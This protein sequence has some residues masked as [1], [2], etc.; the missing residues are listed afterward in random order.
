MNQDPVKQ[1][2]ALASALAALKRTSA[3]FK[4]S[5]FVQNLSKASKNIRTFTRDAQ[6]LR[7]AL[8]ENLIETKQLGDS[9]SR[10][11]SSQYLSR[12]KAF[13]KQQLSWY[14]TKALTFKIMALP[15]DVLTSYSKFNDSLTQIRSVG[16]LTDTQMQNLSVTMKKVGSSTKF[17]A[18]EIAEAA[19][20]LA[21]AGFRG[22]E[23]SAALSPAAKLSTATNA[24][25]NVATDVMST[26]I[27]AYN[28]SSND[29]INISDT[30]TNAVT[31]SKLSLVDLSTAFGYV[32]SAAS[33]TG[34]SFK[35]TVTLLSVLANAGLKASTAATGLRMALLKITAPTRKAKK[36]LA[37]LGLSKADLDIANRGIKQVLQT[38]SQLDTTDIIDIFGARSANAV[39]VFKNVSIDALNAVERLISQSGT[40]AA[41]A[42]EQMLSL[43]K[44]WK[45]LQDKLF[46]MNVAIGETFGESL[47]TNV[48]A[49]GNMV[50]DLTKH[51]SELWTVVKGLALSFG[52][53]KLIKGLGYGNL[54]KLAKG[55]A[56]LWTSLRAG[57]GVLVS[58]GASA[59]VAEGALFELGVAL[60]PLVAL[61]AAFKAYDYFSETYVS[62]E[63]FR[64][65]VVESQ[66]AMSRMVGDAQNLIITL[67]RLSNLQIDQGVKDLVIGAAREKFSEDATTRYDK[68]I[69]AAS[70]YNEEVAKDLEAQKKAVLERIKNATSSDE[71]VKII[72]DSRTNLENYLKAPT[73]NNSLW[74]IQI[75]GTDPDAEKDSVKQRLANTLKKG[76]EEI[77]KSFRDSLISIVKDPINATLIDQASRLLSGET[78]VE[79]VPNNL[80]DLKKLRELKKNRDVL[81][82]KIKEVLS[83]PNITKDLQNSYKKTLSDLE[84]ANFVVEGFIKSF[85]PSNKM[86]AKLQNK[87]KDMTSLIISK[88][89]KAYTNALKAGMSAS[90]ALKDS[91][92]V[93]KNYL[94]EALLKPFREAGIS[95]PIEV[96]DLFNSLTAKIKGTLSAQIEKA[97]QIS[98]NNEN[99]SLLQ[100][101]ITLTQSQIDLA[102]VNGEKYDKLI[103][104]LNALIKK[105]R[106]AEVLQAKLAGK[107]TQVV[108]NKQATEDNRKKAKEIQDNQK[109]QQQA[110]Q[111]TIKYYEQLESAYEK[112]R[113]YNLDSHESE[114]A[115]VRI[116]Q[117][118]LDVHEKLI[119][120]KIKQVRLSKMD[121]TLK[122]AVIKGLEKDLAAFKKGLQKSD[123]EID[124][125]SDSIRNSFIDP[126][127]GMFDEVIEGTVSVSDAF[128]TMAEDVVKSLAKVV[129][130]RLMTN[131]GEGIA[132]LFI[133]D[134]GSFS[135]GYKSYAPGK[136]GGWIQF[137]L[138]KGLQ[139]LA[140]KGMGSFF[141]PSSSGITSPGDYSPN[142]YNPN[143]EFSGL[144]A[145]GGASP[146]SMVMPKGM[147]K[148]ISAPTVNI[149]N[150][151]STA[152]SSG[153]VTVKDQVVSIILEDKANNGLISQ[154]F[155]KSGV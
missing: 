142:N 141:S 36:V 104:D 44:S 73:N 131:V 48:R 46:N 59:V 85:H 37:R 31:N 102:R 4:S 53:F 9:F 24:G 77:N 62:A 3:S 146:V 117:Q 96:Q 7:K 99:L 112:I 16:Q 123:Q 79:A 139:A 23:L 88:A 80:Q 25:I 113:Q 65:S 35:E 127:S 152:I 81:I 86:L 98:A 21:Q 42:N 66:A 33:Q 51:L 125:F 138:T 72:K 30:L 143:V 92:E 119:R 103:E 133:S 13:F 40:A 94:D 105:K 70:P 89:K 137:L 49:F 108:K 74:T 148:P 90:G 57:E 116:N 34:V 15:K 130:N 144:G 64:T 120:A 20:T 126:I 153:Q 151:T 10:T 8:K 11:F 29:F 60:A 67:S 41:I 87:A 5:G 115:N 132:D 97:N 135:P 124:D 32:A 109:A 121:A 71:I 54:K 147:V 84:E 63:Q 61:F 149:T 6:N 83:D 154:S 76:A 140:S 12:S 52:A 106:T 22:E 26:V 110:L 93:I 122:N 91:T 107:S 43:S 155:S 101:Q 118:I 50:V 100:S 1:I 27:R 19:K 114:V 56:T 95:I 17:S 136:G 55:F 68:L 150:N 111:D 134:N 128:K 39:L 38:I 145:S 82:S 75:V 2:N 14:P 45:N 47:A 69:E 58:F 28:K 129:V 78:L 18:A